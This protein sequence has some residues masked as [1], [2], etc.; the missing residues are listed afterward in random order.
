MDSF[1]HKMFFRH[2][3]T[4]ASNKKK[5]LTKVVK[6]YALIKEMSWRSLTLDSFGHKMF[7]SPQPY[8]GL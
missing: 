4:G 2:N 7:I 1:R 8:W 6:E 5:S 3:F